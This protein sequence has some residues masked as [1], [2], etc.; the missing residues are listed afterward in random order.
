MA[1]AR[2]GATVRDWRSRLA[3][4]SAAAVLASLVLLGC[5]ADRGGIPAISPDQHLAMPADLRGSRY[6][7]VIPMFWRGLQLKAEVYNTIGLNDCPTERWN[8]I[9]GHQIAQRYGALRV[10]LNGP[11]YWLMNHI[12]AQNPDAVA[13]TVNFG[14]LQMRQRASIALNPWVLVHGE[15]PFSPQRVQRSTVFLFRKGQMVYELVTN[16]GEIYRMQS[17]A[18]IVDPDLSEK[19]LARLGSRL[20]LPPGWRFRSRRL[21]QDSALRADGEAT[22]LQDELQNSYQKLVAGQS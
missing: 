9:D 2:A 17:F 3:P 22:V 20:M 13:R 1:K 6:C 4:R 16:R 5:G 14:G 18:R 11:R 21:S 12:S 15:Y 10:K 19:D 8:R 7:E